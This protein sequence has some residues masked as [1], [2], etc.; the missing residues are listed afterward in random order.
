MR[1]VLWSLLVSVVVVSL[2]IPAAAQEQVGG[3]LGTV[4]DEQNAPVP[5]ATVE[6]LGSAGSRFVAVTD[7]KGSFRLPRL[8]LDVYTVRVSMPG[9]QPAEATNVQV[10]LGRDRTL[11]FTLRTRF[12]EAVIVTASQVLIDVTKTAVAT[13]FSAEQLAQLPLARDFTAV[14]NLAPGAQVEDA[15]FGGGGISVDGASSA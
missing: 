11:A 13:E 7:D 5:G 8:P 15:F 6:A 12:E 9:M 4:V 2:A 1:R 14:I 3:I 10:V